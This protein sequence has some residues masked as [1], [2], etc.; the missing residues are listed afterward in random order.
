M[1]TIPY[2]CELYSHVNN[3]L[4]SSSSQAKNKNK[5]RVGGVSCSCCKLL[6]IY[7]LL[8]YL[9]R[10][11]NVTRNLVFYGKTIDLIFL[12][13][14]ITTHTH[15]EKDLPPVFSLW[16]TSSYYKPFIYQKKALYCLLNRK[17]FFFFAKSCADERKFSLKMANKG[18]RMFFFYE[19]N[20]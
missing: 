16:Y 1:T 9:M 17:L 12:R 6:L 13:Y 20:G 10:S 11:T 8:I 19:N 15:D 3:V 4:Y 14:S 18:R 7:F 2:D 5:E